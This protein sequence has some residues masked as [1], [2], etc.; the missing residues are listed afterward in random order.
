MVANDNPPEWGI[1]RERAI[2]GFVARIDRYRPKT[3]LKRQL[4]LQS[5]QITVNLQRFACGPTPRCPSL[6]CQEGAAIEF[7]VN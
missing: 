3:G 5:R 6:L 1:S 2:A 7:E 4:G